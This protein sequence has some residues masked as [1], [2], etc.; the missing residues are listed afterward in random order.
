MP[1]QSLSQLN[2]I[3]N[4]VRWVQMYPKCRINRMIYVC[5]GNRFRFQFYLLSRYHFFANSLSIY[6]LILFNSLS[7][8]SLH[9]WL[10]I[11][12]FFLQISAKHNTEYI[13]P[14]NAN[15]CQQRPTF[16]LMWHNRHHLYH[17]SIS[18]I[19]SIVWS[20][21][22]LTWF[23]LNKLIAS[24]GAA[25]GLKNEQTVCSQFPNDGQQ[26]RGFDQKFNYWMQ[27]LWALSLTLY[28][29]EH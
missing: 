14:T 11:G 2:L 18:V 21:V 13:W 28:A 16:G 15:K 10:F 9:I 4:S 27:V 19:E 8:M 26:N 3:S 6:C 17:L 5:E 7:L 20:A 1:S 23:T 25:D 12:L 24:D 29:T 22:L